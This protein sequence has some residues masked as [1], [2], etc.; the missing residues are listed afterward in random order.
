[1]EPD[2][3]DD[4]FLFVLFQRLVIV[5]GARRLSPESSADLLPPR[6]LRQHQPFGF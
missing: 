2:E 5:N 6:H 1:M 3:G 4:I